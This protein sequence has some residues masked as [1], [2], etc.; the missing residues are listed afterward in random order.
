MWVVLLVFAGYFFGNIPIVKKNFT[1]VIMAIIV[2]SVM[3]GVIAYWNERWSAKKAAR[4]KIV[5]EQNPEVN[6]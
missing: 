2:I 6:N 4:A 5:A 1:M 3:P